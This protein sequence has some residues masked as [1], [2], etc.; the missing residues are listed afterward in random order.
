MTLLSDLR[1]P[2]GAPV[3]LGGVFDLLRGIEDAM[4]HRGWT[5]IGSVFKASKLHPW[6]DPVREQLHKWTQADLIAHR[7]NALNLRL[8]DNGVIALDCDFNDWVLM[9]RF[10]SALQ[11]RLGLQKEQLFTCAGKKGGKIF[12]RFQS[13]DGYDQL[14]RTLGP[15]VY[16]KGHV[17]DGS[18]KQEL[19]VKSDLSTIAGLYGPV[20]PVTGDGIVY[21]PYADYPYIVDASPADLPTITSLELQGLGEL[22]LN[23]VKQGGYETAEHQVTEPS[24]L[25]HE[26][27]RACAVLCIGLSY[28]A[29]QER[30]D[31][32]LVTFA[33]AKDYAQ[34]VGLY[35]REFL[36][37]LRFIGQDL[38]CELIEHLLL[39]N[40]LFS[41]LLED[42]AQMLRSIFTDKSIIT[43]HANLLSNAQAVFL[44]STAF[45]H[46]LLLIQSAK[47]GI[48]AQPILELSQTLCNKLWKLSFH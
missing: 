41:P 10:M 32:G 43:D 2:N 38:T 15:T 28:Y 19:E 18:F 26:F 40:A 7:A 29:L 37:L 8:T 4:F 16:L 3:G 47:N 13:F 34:S 48:P 33:E 1:A 12:F 17:G 21:G 42:D 39:D 30:T 44:N 11:L 35:Q 5:V 22:M 45:H 20:D 14:P 9:S 24:V 6:K 23:L 36:P 31:F 27:M 25:D 46:Q